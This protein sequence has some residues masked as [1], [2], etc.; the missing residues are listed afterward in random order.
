MPMATDIVPE[1]VGKRFLIL[2][3]GNVLFGDDGFGPAVVEY[4]LE[5][6]KIPSNT[7][8]MDVGTGAS[9]VLLSVAL[10]GN[11]PEKIIILDAV[12]LKKKTGEIL[13]IKID[14][15]PKSGTRDFSPH[16]FPPVNFLKE[17]QDAFDVD[18]TIVACQIEEIPEFV[19]PGLSKSVKESIPEAAKVALKLA[20]FKS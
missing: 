15:L 20:K 6:H 19:N 3:C 10:S 12:D 16:L 5:N 13:Q 7:Y 9:E 11:P 8:V 17:L 1:Y 4:I 18:I 14:D 2:G